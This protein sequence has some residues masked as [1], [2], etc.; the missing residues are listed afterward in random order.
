MC[1]I[2][3]ILFLSRYAGDGDYRVKLGSGISDLT[4]C[5]ILT[6]LTISGGGI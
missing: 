4:F 1:I 6:L 2:N 5:E 3:C